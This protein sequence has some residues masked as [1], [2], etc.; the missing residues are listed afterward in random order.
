MGDTTVYVILAWCV[1]VLVV[2]VPGYLAYA[3]ESRARRRVESQLADIAETLPGAVFQWRSLPNGRSRYEFLSRQ[4]RELR[5]VDPEAALDDPAVILDT[6]M[7]GD[8]E[9][10]LE[11]VRQGERDGKPIEV[12]YRVLDPR[13]GI[14]WMRT[15]AAPRRMGDGSVLWSGH[16]ADVTEDKRLEEELRAAKEQAD[17]ASRA[18]STFLATMSHEIRTPMNGVL[19]MLELLGMTPLDNE[20]RSSVNVIRESSR[21]LLRIID[22]ILDFSK[23]EA[24]KLEL[25]PEPASIPMVVQRVR[26]IYAGNAS[27]KGLLLR[28]R[29][30]SRVSPWVLAD[31][32]RIQ[33][34]L[35]NLVS[36]AI[37]F[38][39]EGEVAIDVELVDRLDGEDYVRLRVIDT[40]IGVSAEDQQRLFQ[41]F[42]QASESA[43]PRYGGTG[44]GLSIS[45]RLAE[46]MG[47]TIDMKSQPGTGTEVVLSLRLPIVAAPNAATEMWMPEALARGGINRPV[48]AIE[49]ALRERTLVLVVDDHPINRMV[50][51]RQVR[52]LGYAVETAEDG[53]QA[54]DLWSGDRYGLVITDCNMPEL[55]GYQLA[56]H[57]RLSE[58]RHGHP[59]TPV[60]ACTANALGGEAERCLAEGMD[61]YLSKPVELARLAEKLQRWLPLPEEDA[62]AEQPLQTAEVIRLGRHPFDAAVLDEIS[63]GNPVVAREVL[64][65]F[66][67]YNAED[68]AAIREAVAQRNLPALQMASHRVRGSSRTVGATDLAVA[69]ERMERGAQRGDWTEIEAAMGDFDREVARLAEHIAGL[70]A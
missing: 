9:R 1:V 60:I 37:K 69:C 59:R 8:R 11:A 6:L 54:L 53:L 30:D 62:P 27:G 57:I 28:H 38:T 66:H 3:R 7:E 51:A 23:I 67:R 50:L 20:Q 12:D 56:R 68:A 65:R 14:R 26:D 42:V 64:V 47:G 21:S 52:A 19:G 4:T 43:G 61:D 41:P 40:G 35:A 15:S 55:S 25:R 2:L 36:N 22:D 32:V 17:A 48:P 49:Q 44:L 18:K 45:R 63:A 34:I 29:V 31:P 16:W 24:G 58:A 13:G 33:Q 5:G 10:L 39:P 46:L 70:A